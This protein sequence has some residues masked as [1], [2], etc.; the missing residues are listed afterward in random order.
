MNLLPWKNKPESRGGE[1]S[2]MVSL[3]HEMDRLFESFLREPLSAMDW[4]PWGAEKGWIFTMACDYRDGFSVIALS[5][6]SSSAT[7][8]PSSANAASTRRLHIVRQCARYRRPRA[9]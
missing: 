8:A 7:P 3:R 1:I 5:P 2:P 4:S 9:A 6:R